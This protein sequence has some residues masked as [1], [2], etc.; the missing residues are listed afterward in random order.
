MAKI[1]T[2]LTSENTRDIFISTKEKVTIPIGKSTKD[3]KRQS[4]AEESH[5]TL[6]RKK[7][8]CER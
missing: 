4:T 2:Q 3:I 1:S 5:M 8:W 7:Q 6:R